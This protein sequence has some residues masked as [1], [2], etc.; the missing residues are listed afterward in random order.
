MKAHST[1]L[2]LPLLGPR[3]CT[4]LL[5]LLGLAALGLTAGCTQQFRVIT[6]PIF[7]PTANPVGADRSIEVNYNGGGAGTAVVIDLQGEAALGYY[8]TGNG[9]VSVAVNS[10]ASF[11]YIANQNADTVT[12]FSS[13]V[14]GGNPTNIIT[15]PAGSRPSFITAPSGN[16]VYVANPGAGTV[17]VISQ[18][19]QALSGT[20]PV[21]ANPVWVQPST[22]GSKVYVLNQ[23]SGTVTVVAASDLTVLATLPVGASPVAAAISPAGTLFV[24]NQGSNTVSV[25]D[26]S[27]DT[28]GTPLT[29]GS[30]PSA[31]AFDKTL[32][33]LYVLNSGSNTVSVFKADVSPVTP[34]RTVAVGASPVSITVLADGTRFYVANSASNTVSVIDTGSFT[35]TKTIAV[36]TDPIAVTSGSQGL[37]VLVLNRGSNN[38]SLIDTSTDTVA[39]TL[40]LPQ[41]SSD[42]RAVASYTLL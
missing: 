8:I 31:L 3:N 28:V 4:A 19:L 42:P 23:A 1:G 25:I 7:S 13:S 27:T 40:A 6:T 34:L 37:R 5:A 18:A 26:T 10:T 11:Y 2:K 38:I 14:L 16:N 12:A 30:A 22:D 35:V 15:L 32:N 20:V 21:G 36:G 41:G 29:V 17:S 33:R 39:V 9:P 24:A